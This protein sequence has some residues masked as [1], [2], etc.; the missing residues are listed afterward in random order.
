MYIYVKV[1]SN[2]HNTSLAVFEMYSWFFSGSMYI[3]F[4][5]PFIL[6]LYLKT[7]ISKSNLIELH[8]VQKEV[9]CLCLPWSP[10][11]LQKDDRFAHLWNRDNDLK[12]TGMECMCPEKTFSVHLSFLALLL[13]FLAADISFSPEISVYFWIISLCMSKNIIF[14]I[15]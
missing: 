4:F 11:M 13:C 14:L 15:R 8:K 2:S 1:L 3:C 7:L 5:F 10:T 9:A 6:R 12:I